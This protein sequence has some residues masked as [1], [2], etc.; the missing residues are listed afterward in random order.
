MRFVAGEIVCCG[1][2]LRFA[3]PDRDIMFAD[4]TGLNR[5]DYDKTL[6]AACLINDI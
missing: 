2:K 3:E 1:L 4:R 6:L 5:T